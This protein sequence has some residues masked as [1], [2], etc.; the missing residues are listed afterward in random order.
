MK[1]NEI[2]FGISSLRLGYDKNEKNVHK[3]SCNFK[4]I[5]LQMHDPV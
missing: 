5:Q 1:I 3:K 2:L 4:E